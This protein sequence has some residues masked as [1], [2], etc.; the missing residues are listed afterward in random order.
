MKRFLHAAA[1]AA[2]FAV[3]AAGVRADEGWFAG[4][5]L[6]YL[7]P[8]FSGVGF[9]NVFYHGSPVPQFGDG[10]IDSDLDFAQRVSLGYEGSQGGGIQVRWF[11]FDNTTHY[12]GVGEDSGGPEPI[13]GDL[14]IELDAFD[15]E[16]IQRGSFS[17]WDWIGTAGVRYAQYEIREQASDEFEWEEFADAVWFGLAGTEFQGAGPTFS[18]MGSRPVFFEELSFFGRVRTALLYGDIEQDSI[19]IIG[20]GPLEITDEFVQVWEFQAGANFEFEFDAFDLVA[21]IFWEA[22]RWDS[23]SNLL[24]DLA[25]H[26]FG[27]YVGVEY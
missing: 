6:L 22:Q 1:L 26:G 25:L 3:Q 14:G 4:V 15:A 17:A 19:Y 11:T 9:D 16:F 7:A 2:A 20:G 27:T 5:D 18:A 21:S 12:T 13:A 24:G 23:D 8:K 10:A